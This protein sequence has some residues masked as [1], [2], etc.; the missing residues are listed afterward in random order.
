MFRIL[1]ANLLFLAMLHQ[2]RVPATGSRQAIELAI[3][4]KEVQ[5][6]KQDMLNIL[7]RQQPHHHS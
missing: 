6:Q 7:S 3:K 1:L 4:S 2:P 5:S